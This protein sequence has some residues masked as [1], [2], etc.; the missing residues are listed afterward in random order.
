[1]TAGMNSPECLG[2]CGAD[3]PNT[4]TQSKDLILKVRDSTVNCHYK[5]TYGNVSSCGSHEACR[6]HDACFDECARTG[7]T[8]ET[9][10]CHMNCTK[11]C[12]DVHGVIQCGMLAA[13]YGPY[14]GQILYSNYPNMTGPFA[15]PLDVI[16]G[17]VAV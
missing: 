4:C 15:E 16:E 14:N 7:E 2:A 8:S 3:G 11:N 9:A 6:K 12:T 1:M 17:S 10:P 13:G 5:C